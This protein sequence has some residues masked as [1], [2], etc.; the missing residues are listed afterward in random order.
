MKH[1][2]KLVPKDIVRSK[3][4]D[5][6]S[7]LC[8]TCLNP[9]LKIEACLSN[10]G[11][12]LFVET[13]KLVKC[14]ESKLKT[15]CEKVKSCEKLSAIFTGVKTL[16]VSGDSQNSLCIRVDWSENGNQ[17]R[18]EKGAYYHEPQVSINAVVA[19]MS[20]SVIS[21]CT[22]SDTKSHKVTAVWASLEKVLSSFDLD[23]V[24]ILYIITDSLTSQHR[25]K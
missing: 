3:P 22:I 6:G 5:W 13:D 2:C 17:A 21:H 23:K 10:V 7:C 24:Q 9:Q 11:K 18:Q 4:K 19:Y 20:T 8:Q 16:L 15:F 12:S 25:S 1:F 14:D